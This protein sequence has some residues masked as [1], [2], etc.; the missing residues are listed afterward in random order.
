MLCKLYITVHNSAVTIVDMIY[1]S[2][3]KT[4]SIVY[5]SPNK[6]KAKEKIKRTKNNYYTRRCRLSP[7]K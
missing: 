4:K 5:M 3:S 6:T 7:R 2:I 1:A